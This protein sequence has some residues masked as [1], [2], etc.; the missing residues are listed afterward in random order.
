M[1]AAGPTRRSAALGECG[2]W[3]GASRPSTGLEEA[4][5][6]PRA[7]P[8]YAWHRVSGIGCGGSGCLHLP[9]PLLLLLQVGCVVITVEMRMCSPGKL[10]QHLRTVAPVA[11]LL[12]A[13]PTV[14]AAAGAESGGPQ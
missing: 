12:I 8:R 3:M 5:Q 10:L 9:R 7:G 11:A 14:T 4:S 2:M 1:R 6:R 13:F